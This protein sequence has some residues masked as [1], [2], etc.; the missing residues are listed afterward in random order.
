MR[1]RATFDG[2]SPAPW[3][4]AKHIYGLP[5]CLVDGDGRVLGSHFPIANGPLLEEARRWRR[6]FASSSPAYRQ[7]S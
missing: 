1:L 7:T 5:H 6:S 4:F 3:I 2:P